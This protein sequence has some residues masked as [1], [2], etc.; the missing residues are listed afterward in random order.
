LRFVDRAEADQASFLFE[1]SIISSTAPQRMTSPGLVA[2]RAWDV[3]LRMFHW[4]LVA[5]FC[6]QLYSGKVGGNS[7][8]WHLYGGYAVFT[9]VLFRVLWGFAG[10]TH[11]RFADFVSGPSAALR[12]A[13]TLVSPR[14]AHFIGHNPLGGWM[15]LAFL[16]LLAV[17]AATGLFANDDIA[18]EGPLASLVSKEV[19]DRLTTIHRW[20]LKLLLV[21][22]VLHVGAVLYHRFVK[23]E[24]LIRAMFTGVKHVPA[25][26]AAAASTPRRASAWLALVLFA[27]ASAAVFLIVKRPF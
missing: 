14:P 9:L 5:L 10:G 1:G 19:S 25:E 15:V 4:F 6:F 20:N 26:V 17:Q 23:R 3:P 18:T 27:A 11:A 22:A 16:V 7:M 21:L 24:D 8:P 2:T 12:F 13:K